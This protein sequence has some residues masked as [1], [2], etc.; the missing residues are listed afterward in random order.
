[1]RR[2][3]GLSFRGALKALAIVWCLAFA[4]AVVPAS[5]SAADEAFL[6]H[7]CWPNPGPEN[8]GLDWFAYPD[9]RY[10]ASEGLL[11]GFGADVPRGRSYTW[12][13]T[14]N[15]D[16]ALIRD[17][18]MDVSSGEFDNGIVYSLAVC[19]GSGC[20]T[21]SVLDRDND[22]TWIVPGL[23]AQTIQIRAVCEADSCPSQDTLPDPLPPDPGI[24]SLWPSFLRVS[25]FRLLIED[26]S[27]PVLSVFGADY[28]SAFPQWVRPQLTPLNVSAVDDGVGIDS[29]GLRVDPEGGIGET[30]LVEWSRENRCAAETGYAYDSPILCPNS[31]WNGGLVDLSSLNDGRYTLRAGAMDGMGNRAEVYQS[32]FAVDGTPPARLRDL[33]AT[34]EISNYGWTADPLLRM[35]WIDPINGPPDGGSPIES[36]WFD[37]DPEGVPT[38]SDP[39]EQRP[40]YLGSAEA[41][42]AGEGLWRV[43]Y[44]VLDEVGNRSR[45]SELVVGFDRDA[46][47]P[48]QPDPTPWLS[49]PQLEDGYDVEWAPPP[50]LPTLESG[51][52][53][54]AVELNGDPDY[55]PPERFDVEAPQTSYRLPSGLPEGRHNVN[56]R[57]VSCAGVGS[58]VAGS[59]PVDVDATPPSV[60]VEGLPAEAWARRP[61][62]LTV[63][64]DDSLSGVATIERVLDGNADT[65][66]GAV[67]GLVVGEGLHELEIS[68]TDV[69]GNR[70]SVSKHRLRVDST[71]PQA[72]FEAREPEAPG[73]LV[74]TAHDATSGV[75]SAWIEVRRFGSSES[76]WRIL[77]S[78]AKGAGTPGEPLRVT[79]DLPDSL[80]DGAYELRVIAVDEAGNSADARGVRLSDAPMTVT[81]PVR[82]RLELSA[83]LAP[84]QLMRS[85][86]SCTRSAHTARN[87]NCT[88]R[89]VMS[90]KAAAQ[91]PVDHP[92]RAALLIELATRRGTPVRSAEL[93]VR[94]TVKGRDD[95]RELRTRT[96]D[97]GRARLLLPPGPSRNFSVSYAGSDQLAA[98]HDSARLRVRAGVRF[99][100]SKRRIRVG[101]RVRLSGRVL[102]SHW[103]PES[104]V[105]VDFAFFRGDG[106]DQI[107][108]PVFTGEDGRFS[109]PP[110]RP[111]A[112]LRPTT[113]LLRSRVERAFGWPY[114][115]GSSRPVSLTVVP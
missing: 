33:R 22:G 79:A 21:R 107:L 9:F 83:E 112:V 66:A 29:A 25:K 43:A 23:H 34:S 49:P 50:V 63:T 71:P 114:E 68:S 87:A 57:S 94:E 18:I 113:Y 85:R 60:A 24:P 110:W 19:G 5:A 86:S 41:V 14:T 7:S 1:M 39:P 74:A 90:R 75:T 97:R 78:A 61:L 106:Y 27:S 104:S 52:C 32:D 91:L 88:R 76:D 77:P 45:E 20:E 13:Y 38:R 101:E 111:G 10:C 8:D 92:G 2:R 73:R 58:Q 96:D 95:V 93:V 54:Y 53:G 37:L 6:V 84:V 11:L 47:E 15:S 65:T 80:A 56:V 30:P 105:R 64:A 46:P 99:A 100:I 3:S 62:A 17:L 59:T 26:S 89:K 82:T 67:D 35:A 102:G 103:H 109:Y 12:E 98:T 36:V 42:F 40:R 72:V 69:A 28:G 48:V 81:M 70:S 44:W 115:A 108:D 55:L 51:V 4:A 16:S 31:T